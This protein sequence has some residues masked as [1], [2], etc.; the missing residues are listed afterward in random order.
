VRAILLNPRYTGRQVWNRQRRDEVLVDVDEVALGHETKLRWN[1]KADWIWSNDETHEALVSADDYVR[2]QEQMAAGRNRPAIRKARSTPRP[3]LLRG[4]LVCGLCGR[5]MSG[6]HNHA[7][8]YYRCRYP[9]EYALANNV[10]HPR[11]VYLRELEVVTQLD[12]WFAQLFDPE[13]LDETCAELAEASKGS[14]SDEAAIEAARRKVT[15]CETRLA[16]YR[17]ALKSGTDPAVVSQWIAEVQGEKLRAEQALATASRD[18]FDPDQI[19]ALIEQLGP[20]VDVLE[21]AQPAAKAELYASLGLQ[22]T[23]RPA[24]ALVAVEAT[25]VA[26]AKVRV[27]GGLVDLRHAIS[28]TRTVSLAV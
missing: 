8:A 23:Y 12:R 14:D 3:Y 26:C 4:L 13:H 5:R 10:E 18:E 20:V 1:D 22:L 28:L 2:V 15:D 17:A 6:Q 25:P 21:Q 11:T 19:R 27:G 24:Q 9:T 16:R 7:E